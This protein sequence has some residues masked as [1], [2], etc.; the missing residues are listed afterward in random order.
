MNKVRFFFKKTPRLYYLWFFAR[1]KIASISICRI[2]NINELNKSCS[3]LENVTPLLC[4]CLSAY[5]HVRYLKEHS[6]AF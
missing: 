3:G 5:R 2:E 1:S 6:F 4:G